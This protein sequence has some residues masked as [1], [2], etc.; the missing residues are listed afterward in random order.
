MG[1]LIVRLLATLNA[2]KIDSTNYHIALI[3]LTNYDLISNMSIG[4][5]ANLCSVSKSTISKFARSLGFDDYF[6]LKDSSHFVENRFNNDKN[7]NDNVLG[8][9]NTHGIE[10]YKYAIQ[11][12]ITEFLGKIYT[13]HTIRLANDI[14]SHKIVGAFGLLFSEL[15]A[16]DLQYKLAYSNKYLVTFQDDKKQEKFIC[17]A[18]EDTLIILYSNS[19]TFIDKQQI[20]LGQPKKTILKRQ[21]QKSL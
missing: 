19:G 9:I 21:K 2:E 15:G 16:I 20:V 10:A 8:F 18:D 11:N 17:E 6:D 12:D 13:S 14:Q 3:L 5:I 7:F 1:I 4:E